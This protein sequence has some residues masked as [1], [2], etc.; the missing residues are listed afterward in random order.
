MIDLPAPT[1]HAVTPGSG[2][3]AELIAPKDLD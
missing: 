1:W 2:D 3:I